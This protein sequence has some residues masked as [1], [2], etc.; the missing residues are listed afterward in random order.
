[1]RH[2]SEVI[3]SPTRPRPYLAAWI[4][5]TLL[6]ALLFTIPFASL[7]IS[8][9]EIILPAYAGAMFTLELITASLL[10]TL[11]NAQRSPA[12]LILGSG[13]LFAALTV[14]GWVLTFPGLFTALGIEA[15]LQTTATIAAL[16]RLGFAFFVLIYA[17]TPFAGANVKSPSAII[18]KAILTVLAAVTTIM[19]LLI[20]QQMSLPVFMQDAH[21][22][23]ALWSIVPG[24]AMTVYLVSLTILIRRRRA[25]LDLWICLV[26]FSLMIELALLSYISDGV[27]FSV[28]W[29]A[30]RIYGLAA[31]GTV[32]LVLLADTT[33]VY[34]RLAQ[35]LASEQRTRQ[36]RLTA[37]EALSASI[38]HEINQPLASIITNADA[39]LRWL[40]RA[41]PRIDKVDASLQAIV[42][43]G[44]RANKIV[45]GIRTMFM[46]GAQEREPVDLTTIVADVTASVADETKLANIHIELQ[47]DPNTPIINGNPVQ[48]RQVIWNLVEN[49]IDSM[50]AVDDRRR[51]LSIQT[52]RIADGQAEVTVEDSG[53]GLAPGAEAQ[54]FEPF[55]SSKPGGMGM[56]LMFCRA[57]VEAHG[58]R[59]WVAPN[60][61]RGA[62]F[63]LTLPGVEIAD[64]DREADNGSTVHRLHRR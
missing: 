17:L 54:I 10:F 57:V 7:K 20:R 9:S 14:P 51:E 19:W 37:M 46:K 48:L 35:S 13:Y 47:L 30:G 36:N 23:T 50:K 39:G 31:A 28:G 55:F 59:L 6:G 8:G 21:N 53:G 61:S 25:A 22:V 1:M 58:G 64:Y 34:A 49:S 4:A 40:A 60:V 44:H 5:A 33:A 12:L 16:R 3:I 56:G 26:L 52:W 24:V 18:L 43:D 41:E 32:L 29:W 27:R 45:S 2:E 15:G 38:A 11:Y 42:F 63:H 62:I